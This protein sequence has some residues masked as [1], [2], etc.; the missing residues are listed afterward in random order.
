MSDLIGSHNGAVDE[1]TLDAELG[2]EKSEVELLREELLGV[3]SMLAAIMAIMLGAA[4]G[5]EVNFVE[6]LGLK[7]DELRGIKLLT[8]SLH[9]A[10]P[11]ARI[12]GQ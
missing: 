12:R 6:S 8:S 7:L 5:A 4:K 10:P 9:L 3:R 1:G 11:N 2:A